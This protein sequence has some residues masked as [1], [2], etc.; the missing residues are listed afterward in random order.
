MLEEDLA[1]NIRDIYTE[2]LNV[3]SSVDEFIQILN[4]LSQMFNARTY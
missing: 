3:E 2:I 4:G 1:Q